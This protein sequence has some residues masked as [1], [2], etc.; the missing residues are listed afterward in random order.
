MLF[1]MQRTTWKLLNEWTRSKWIGAIHNIAYFIYAKKIPLLHYFNLI[2]VVVVVAQIPI[3]E[4]P[5][6]AI[7]D[8]GKLPFFRS[9]W[10]A[11]N[12]KILC[13]WK[14][15]IRFYSLSEFKNVEYVKVL[16][17][18]HLQWN[19]IRVVALHFFFLSVLLQPQIIFFFCGLEK[20]TCVR[21]ETRISI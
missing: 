4:Y 11:H 17:S 15:D 19:E 16:F 14:I 9:G 7:K 1:S 13:T 18:L 21:Y 12:H 20:L 5:R 3:L 2:L 6:D 8:A 10:K